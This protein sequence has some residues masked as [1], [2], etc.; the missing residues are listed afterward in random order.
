MDNPCNYF[1]QRKKPWFTHL[2]VRAFQPESLVIGI[3]SFSVASAW[4]TAGH[5]VWTDHTMSGRVMGDESGPLRAS[6]KTLL[7]VL[8]G[9]WFVA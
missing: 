6:V 3:Y 2:N 1:K 7:P 4:G 9:M 5:F 8:L